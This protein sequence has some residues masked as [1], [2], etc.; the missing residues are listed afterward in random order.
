MLEITLTIPG[1]SDDERP[2]RKN[3]GMAARD[4][5]KARKARQ[6]LDRAYEDLYQAMR[7]A[8]ESG[9]TITDIADHTGVRHQ[10]VQEIVHGGRPAIAPTRKRED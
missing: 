1:E 6:L 7:N 9:E 10:R 3:P 2:S 8:R 5:R 4:L